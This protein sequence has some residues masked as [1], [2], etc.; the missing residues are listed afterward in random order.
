MIGAISGDQ[1]LLNWG[2]MILFLF[3]MTQIFG[4]ISLV[5]ALRHRPVLLRFG[6]AGVYISFAAGFLLFA[7]VFVSAVNLVPQ[8]L[9]DAMGKGA[10]FAFSVPVMSYWCFAL[11]AALC[12]KAIFPKNWKIYV[13]MMHGKR[14]E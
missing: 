3:A 12:Y 6:K 8:M 5:V 11:M 2:P 13:E 10:V 7:K 9:P 1:E 4:G 14:L